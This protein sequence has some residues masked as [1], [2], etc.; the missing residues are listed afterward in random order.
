MNIPRHTNVLSRYVTNSCRPPLSLTFPHKHALSHGLTDRKIIHSPILSPYIHSHTL[1][2]TCSH[3]YF[4][5]HM[6]TQIS[7]AWQVHKQ[8]LWHTHI[9]CMLINTHTCAF[10]HSFTPPKHL[11]TYMD[12]ITHSHLARIIFIQSLTNKHTNTH[13]LTVAHRHTDIIS[14]T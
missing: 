3:I 10:T 9:V 13:S 7:H 11:Y 2:W 8:T 14:S 6:L 5:N 1:T 12:M 4:K